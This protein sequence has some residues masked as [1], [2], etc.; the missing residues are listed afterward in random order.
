M[1]A[2][3]LYIVI[4]GVFFVVRKLNFTVAV[5]MRWSESISTVFEQRQLRNEFI[6]SPLNI[7]WCN[8]ALLSFGCCQLHLCLPGWVFLVPAMHML[9]ASQRLISLLP[10]VSLW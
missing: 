1:I 2:L 9:F 10:L 4:F 6:H 7:T 3:W 5:T 8:Y